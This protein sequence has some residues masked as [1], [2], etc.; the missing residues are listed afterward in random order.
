[1]DRKNEIKMPTNFYQTIGDR[2]N[3]KDARFG[4]EKVFSNSQF[5]IA[6]EN[7]SHRGYF[8]EKILNCFA[9]GT[10]PVY[11]GSPNVN[12]YFDHQGIIT[13]SKIHDLKN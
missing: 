1:M 7:F 11:L 12:K 5:G 10:V 9:Q 2:H 4:K 13:F 8:T 6:I 3:T